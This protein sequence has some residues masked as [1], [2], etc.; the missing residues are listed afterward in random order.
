MKKY[1]LFIACLWYAG[2]FAQNNIISNYVD[3][4][5]KA[6]QLNGGILVAENG[7]IMTNQAFGYADFEKGIPNT[8]GTRFNL[9]SIS[10]V[11]TSTA[12]LQLRDKGKL[13]LTD[14]LNKFF[15]D[16][17]YPELTVW[18]LL[19]HTSGLPDLELYENLVRQYPDTV[20]TNKNIIPELKKFKPGLHGKPGDNCRY[21]NVNYSL[22]AMVVEKVSGLSFSDYLVKYIFKPA[23]MKDTYLRIY[24]SKRWQQDSRGAQM[25]TLPHPF[26][27][28]TYRYADSSSKYDN[29]RYC[30]FNCSGTIGESNIYAT[31]AD[32]A[33][34]D[35]AF[36]SGQLLKRA[37]MEEAFTPVKLNNGSTYYQPMD[38]IQGEGKMAFGLGW[39]IFKQPGFS[40]A[41]GHAGFFY[42]NIAFYYHVSD[43]KQFIT[44][45][46][47]TA[48]IAFGRIITSTLY[49]LN[50]RA[51][52][53][54]KD[55]HSLAFVY[56]STLVKDG[57][58]A[59]A[60]AFN[61]VK[62]DTAHYY[63]SEWEFNQLGGNL[64]NLS[65][66]DGHGQLA[67]EV[68]KLNTI[69]F[70]NSANTYDSYAYGLRA[71]GRKKDAIRMYQK[72]L[73]MDPNNDEGKQALKE[74]MNEK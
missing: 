32:L 64:I 19:S 21:S 18:N 5:G 23:G 8:L 28:S 2:A 25:H 47:N 72:S 43:K 33:A 11:F 15:Q 63:L 36:F 74:L 16:F 26:Y 51:T 44:G 52:M 6:K 67:L 29:I 62:S 39:D 70:S 73:A 41:V 34:F 7:R 61:Q 22:L 13:S 20:I 57:P 58:D 38:C 9:C 3:Q 68:F 65:K 14:H 27:D 42:G 1:I 69:L 59:A 4:A 49:M 37:T 66:F 53:P 24:P 35:R 71:M 54:A 48:G 17:P 31:T 45:Y 30:N 50:G 46:D 40:K 60:A 56:G 10:K 55:K 12:I